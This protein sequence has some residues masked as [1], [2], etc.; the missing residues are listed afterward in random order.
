MTKKGLFIS[1]E[2]LD[3]SG[4]TTLI[5]G[6]AAALQAEGHEVVVTRNPGGTPL[7]LAIRKLLLESEGPM[8]PMAELLLYLADRADHLENVIMPALSR[9]AVVIC[10]RYHDSTLAYQGA[11]RGL[12]EATIR[13]L[14]TAATGGRA[15]DVTLL[16][17]AEPEALFT[18]LAGRGGVPDRLEREPLAFKQRV[19]AGFLRQ[20]QA[21]PERVQI[22]DALQPPDAVLAQALA[23]VQAVLE[24]APAVR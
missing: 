23:R 16:L 7:G 24:Q 5:G 21:A 17:D 19:R 8:A 2:G 11:G 3:G 18:R 22:L 6:L 9:G 15:P 12:D 14:N 10:D 13:Q 4:K 20:A 1:I